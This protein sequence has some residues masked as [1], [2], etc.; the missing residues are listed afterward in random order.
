VITPTI[1]PTTIPTNIPTL[2]F[3]TPTIKIGGRDPVLPTI[4]RNVGTQIYLPMPT[5]PVYNEEN[6]PTPIP[7][8]VR[9]GLKPFPIAT[10]TPFS[11]SLPQIH[12][13]PT[14]VN[15]VTRKPLGFLKYVFT[16]IVKYDQLLEQNINNSIPFMKK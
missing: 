7:I 13:N 2:T 16:T 9:N 12:I 1:T 3:P 10:S 6:T 4:S 11:F 5:E 14:Q 8:N 15:Q